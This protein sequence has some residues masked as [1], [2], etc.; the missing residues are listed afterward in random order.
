[1]D[2]VTLTLT[3]SYGD[4]WNGGTL[5]IDGVTYDQP[6]TASGGASDTYTLCVDLSTCIDVTYSAGSYSSE[7]S[8]S[9]SDASGAVLA[10][11]GAV[12]GQIGACI[13]LVDGCTDST[14]LNYDPLANND[15]GSCVFCVYGC[16]D[17]IAINYDALATCDDASC[18]APING[19][20]DS[21]ALNYYPG[22][23]IDDGNCCF[24]SGCTDDLYTEYDALACID[25]GSCATLVNQGSCNYDSPTGAYTS[26]LIHDRVTMNWDNMNDANCM[27]E[28]Y[29]IR[30]R[31]VGTSAWSS[32]TM[33]GSGLCIFG[34]NTTS[35]TLLG[36]TASTTYEY[37]MKAWY[38]GGPSSAW[39]TLQNFTTLDI[40]LNVDN[41]AAST[42]TTTKATFTWTLPATAYSFARIKLRVDTVGSTWTTAGGFGVFYPAVTKAKNGLNPGTTYR[43]SV[44]TWCD[45][46]GGPYRSAAWSTPIFWTQPASIRLEGG[47]AINNLSIYPNPSRDIFNVSFTSEDAQDLEVR[48]INVVG[49]VVYTEN[50][51]QFVGEYTKQVDLATYTKGIYFLEITT[52]NGVVNKKLIIQ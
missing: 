32:K 37:Y 13:V 51:E 12:S 36:L 9:I 33:S 49:E 47:T 41:F 24:V 25:D 46:N 50:L 6:T 34:L 8:W 16:T 44:R 3:D 35:K 29:R 10:S 52:N 27:V 18:I 43:A 14:A 1:L 21:T 48:V 38:C 42:P 20:T 5:T 4:T 30:Y 23:N 17:S 39:S 2:E 15:D 19:C 22:A 7:N 31:E 40:C 45:A 11:G 26:A 28:Q